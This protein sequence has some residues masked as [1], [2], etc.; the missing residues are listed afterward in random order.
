MVWE[1]LVQNLSTIIE[2]Q[3]GVEL[4]CIQGALAEWFKAA[5]LKTAGGITSPESS[6]LSGSS[7]NVD[8]GSGV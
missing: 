4:F 6:N 2:F 8:F 1:C 5:V 7:M 3:V